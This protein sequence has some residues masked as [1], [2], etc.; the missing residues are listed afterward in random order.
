MPIHLYKIFIHLFSFFVHL[1]GTI[2]INIP[3]TST[4]D[5]FLPYYFWCSINV[6]HEEKAVL[7]NLCSHILTHFD[8]NKRRRSLFN[9]L[10]FVA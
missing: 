2:N 3:V 7:F 1:L 4:C 6:N 8:C 9:F 5:F 10:T